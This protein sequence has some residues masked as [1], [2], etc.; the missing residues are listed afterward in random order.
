LLMSPNA[1]FRFGCGSV[2]ERSLEE[3]RES[4]KTGGMG[5]EGKGQRATDPVGFRFEHSG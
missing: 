2:M 4:G 1:G 3:Q 5:E